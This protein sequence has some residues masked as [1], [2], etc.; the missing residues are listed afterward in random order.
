MNTIYPK[1]NYFVVKTVGQPIVQT[2]SVLIHVE[3]TKKIFSTKEV[4]LAETFALGDI[5]RFK[6]NHPG[7]GYNNTE[8]WLITGVVV[9]DRNL[10]YEM[11]RTKPNPNGNETQTVGPDDL[12]G[13]NENGAIKVNDRILVI[14][15][16]DYKYKIDLIKA[17]LNS[18]NGKKSYILD[19][20]NITVD[21]KDIRIWEDKD[22]SVRDKFYMISKLL[23]KNEE[24]LLQFQ[25][26]DDAL[27]MNEQDR[28]ILQ[29]YYK[30]FMDNRILEKK[31]LKRLNQLYKENLEAKKDFEYE[32]KKLEAERVQ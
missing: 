22:Q 20:L 10:L 15:K 32:L 23:R 24:M 16:G 9:K 26:A 29:S 25:M 30:E 3:G 17:I 12:I 11:S 27:E 2:G 7:L 31:T 8:T 18:E 6:E 19:S 21:E 5:V 13:V 4:A 28:N 1:G 14:K